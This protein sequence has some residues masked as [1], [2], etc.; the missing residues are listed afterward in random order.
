MGQITAAEVQGGE[1]SPC[2]TQRSRVRCATLPVS[3]KRSVPSTGS[4]FLQGQ[5]SF[6]FLQRGCSKRFRSVKV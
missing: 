2:G 6:I 5:A 4:M 1:G 3:W